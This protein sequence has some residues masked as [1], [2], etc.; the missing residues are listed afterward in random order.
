MFFDHVAGCAAELPAV[1]L[2]CSINKG[3]VQ[4]PDRL[5]HHNRAILWSLGKQYPGDLADHHLLDDDSHSTL[6]RVKTQLVSIEQR[7]I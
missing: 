5:D 2:N 6:A 1:R 7:T 3:L 4:T